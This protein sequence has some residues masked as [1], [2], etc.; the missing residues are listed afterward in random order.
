MPVENVARVAACGAVFGV[1]LRLGFDKP[2]CVGEGFGGVC[3]V[4]GYAGFA[5]AFGGVVAPLCGVSVASTEHV[6]RD[7]KSSSKGS[8]GGG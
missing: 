3:G 5:G 1:V 6:V 2:E 4:E 8:D 7:V